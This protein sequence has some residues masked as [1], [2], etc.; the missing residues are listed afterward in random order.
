MPS[1]RSISFE[2]YFLPRPGKLEEGFQGLSE[3]VNAS[4]REIQVIEEVLHQ[5]RG[6]A[7][8][9]SLEGSRKAAEG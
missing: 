3:I 2:R 5:R 1:S 9:L 8:D 7:P 4:G 6:D